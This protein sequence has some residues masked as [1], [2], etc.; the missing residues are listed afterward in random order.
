MNELK[1]LAEQIR[2]AVHEAI[3]TGDLDSPSKPA[4][5]TGKPDKQVTDLSENLA[6]HPKLNNLGTGKHTND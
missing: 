5:T 2:A 4:E 3:D 6:K 1:S